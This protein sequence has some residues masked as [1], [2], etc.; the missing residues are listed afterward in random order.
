[1]FCTGGIRCEKA[2]SY[3]TTMGIEQTYHLK[4]GILRYLHETNESE[5]RFNGDCFVFDERIAVGHELAVNAEISMCYGCRHPVD[6][7]M[8]ADPRYEEGVSCPDCFAATTEEQKAK[9][10]MR[11]QQFKDDRV[12]RSH[13]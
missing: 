11:S 6:E 3:L 13:K 5:S 12:P 8:R 9:F 7:T 2:T 1:M 4:G 10:R